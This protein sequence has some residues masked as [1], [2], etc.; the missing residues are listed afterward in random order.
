MQNTSEPNQ[1]PTI[2]KRFRRDDGL[3]RLRAATGV[4]YDLQRL[5]LATENRG[6][7]RTAE[8]SAPALTPADQ[9]F[10]KSNSKAMAGL[11][12]DAALH[13]AECLKGVPIWEE[14]LKHV[15][16]L[17]PVMGA[18]LITGFDIHSSDKPSS[19]WQHAGLG[20]VQGPDGYRIQRRERGVKANYNPE[21]KTRLLGV[22]SGTLM[23]AYSL[24]SKGYFFWTGQSCKQKKLTPGEFCP[25]CREI[26]EKEQA[27][28]ALQAAA[29]AAGGKPKKAAKKATKKSKKAEAQAE[30]PEELDESLEVKEDEAICAHRSKQYVDPRRIPVW[31]KVADD[32]K[33]R[34]NHQLLA[35]CMCCNG[36]GRAKSEAKEGE[37]EGKTV[38]CWNCDGTGGPAPWGKSDMHRLR[39]ALRYMIKMFVLDFIREWK[40]LEGLPLRAPYEEE[41]LGLAHSVAMP[42]P[43]PEYHGNLD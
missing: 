12:K 10:F 35:V 28:A 15:R 19:Y 24:D 17:G 22:L 36:T 8:E 7:P 30:A 31:R 4:Y 1:A 42:H 2:K 13:I 37:E 21:M 41:K 29:I 38:K 11:E 3:G 32:R 18:V 23:K 33:H 43:N 14:Y 6:R 5:R 26:W 27:E 20:M 25:V 40:A 39:D 34:R 9:A 16:G